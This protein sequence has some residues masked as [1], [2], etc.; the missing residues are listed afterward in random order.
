MIKLIAADLDGTLL[1]DR[2]EVSPEFWPLYERLRSQGILFAV[3]SGRQYYNLADEFSRI[4]SD[5]LIIA[6]N[7]AY[8]KRGNEEVFVNA[9]DFSAVIDCVKAA[10]ELDGA[11][12]VVCGKRS[13]WAEDR[14]DAFLRETRRYY[15]EFRLVDDLT[16]VDDEILK[17]SVCDF[18]HA[19]VVSYPFFKSRLGHCTVTLGGSQWVDIANPTANKGSALQKVGAHFAIG[20]EEMMA[21]GDYLNDREMLQEAY[22]SFAMKNAHPE[23]KQVARYVIPFDNNEE[24]VVRTIKRFIFQEN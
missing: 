16:L 1:D 20:S 22:H 8:A 9:M 23:V 5:L 19:E 14:D 11:Y 21:F 12:A 24:G 2:K 7:G 10:R 6:E 13:A 15:R 18:T 3:A 4:A 17:V